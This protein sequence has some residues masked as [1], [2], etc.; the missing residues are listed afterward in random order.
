MSCERFSNPFA[1]ILRKPCSTNLDQDDA[2]GA[3][4]AIALLDEGE[5][6]WEAVSTALAPYTHNIAVP[7]L[8]TILAALML[9][10][11]MSRKQMI[12]VIDSCVT[13]AK[14]TLGRPA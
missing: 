9:R 13:V 3:A 10:D 6:C 12:G 11:Q 14:T 7:V 8:G 2:E 4:L 1:A 5:A